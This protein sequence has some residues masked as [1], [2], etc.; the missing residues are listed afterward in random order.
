MLVEVARLPQPTQPPQPL[1]LWWHV[2]LDAAAAAEGTN[3]CGDLTSPDLDR[4]WRAY[5][6]RFDLEQTFRFLKQS[7]NWT[8]PRVRHPEQADR[9]TWLVA[10]AYPQLRLARPLVADQRLPWERPL[11]P[12]HVTPVRV[13]RAFSC[14]LPV[15]ACSLFVPAPNAWLS[16]ETAKTL[17]PL[18]WASQREALRPRDPLSGASQS[19]PSTPWRRLIRRPHGHW[20]LL[21]RLPQP[22]VRL[23]MVKSQA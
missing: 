17:R 3:E 12:Q 6:R 2:S 22:A 7:L 18:A 10:L 16:S 14:L 8:Q 19:R 1:W 5:V 4:S 9:W 21:R 11:S 13:R 15:R 20:S 23:V